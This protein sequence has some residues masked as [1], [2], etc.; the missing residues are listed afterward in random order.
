MSSMS[1]LR[2]Y[3]IAKQL[4]I[5]SARI[6][7]ICK[8]L[9]FDVKSHSSTVDEEQKKKI[10][11]EL[12]RLSG[13]TLKKESS[14]GKAAGKASGEKSAAKPAIKK[15]AAA[16]ESRSISKKAE[17]ITD[18]SAGIPMQEEKMPQEPVP[19]SED[20]KEDFIDLEEEKFIKKV[21]AKDKDSDSFKNKH[22]WDEEKRINIRKVLD[23]ELD[24]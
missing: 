19:K 9:G 12:K 2:I 4:G 13:D 18:M 7:E 3:E 5:P 21:Q 10:I 20:E 24:R 15:T 14:S 6:I 22:T 1:S 23:K 16:A 11:S 8:N 17:K